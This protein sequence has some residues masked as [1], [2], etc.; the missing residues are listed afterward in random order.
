MA[1]LKLTSWVWVSEATFN[2]EE[3]ALECDCECE[4]EQ[5]GGG[6]ERVNQQLQQTERKANRF[7][8]MFVC[9]Y[10]TADSGH[11]NSLLQTET[12]KYIF[13]LK[14]GVEG[15]KLYIFGRQAGHHLLL[16]FPTPTIACNTH[17]HT[18]IYGQRHND[19]EL[20]LLLNLLTSFLFWGE[21]NLK[22]NKY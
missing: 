3:A 10:R 5:Q 4:R 15:T 18:Y 9:M 21:S 22:F 6:R 11:H 20:H 19:I 14:G 7:V 1:K 13:K 12:I 2:A 17:T 8:R 16:A